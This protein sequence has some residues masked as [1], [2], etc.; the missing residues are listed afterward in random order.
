MKREIA[1]VVTSASRRA[2]LLKD[3]LHVDVDRLDELDRLLLVE[4]HLISR[5]H[6]EA[7]G[8]AAW[9][10]NATSRRR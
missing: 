7:A 2:A 5:Q 9:L 10:F 3:W 4:R 8:R 1:E 6:A